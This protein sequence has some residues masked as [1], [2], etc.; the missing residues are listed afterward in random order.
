MA[1]WWP[2]GNLR[3]RFWVARPRF[4]EGGCFFFCGLFFLARRRGR[5][6][7]VRQELSGVKC[8]CCTR[9]QQATPRP[10]L[11]SPRV[12]HPTSPLK[13][14]TCPRLWADGVSGLGRFRNRLGLG[15]CP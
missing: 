10:T 3:E 6:D 1:G 4:C 8:K 9:T 15:L 14:E 7:N 2:G 11:T 12:G 5:R 13:Q